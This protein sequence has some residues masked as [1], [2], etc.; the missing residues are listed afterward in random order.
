MAFH[1]TTQPRM[2]CLPLPPTWRR[3]SHLTQTLEF[4]QDRLATGSKARNLSLRQL[5]G[6]ANEMR[7][8]GLTSIAPGLIHPVAVTDQDAATILDQRPEGFL[9]TLGMNTVQGDGIRDHAP[10]PLQGMAAVPGRLVNVAHPCLAGQASNGRIVRHNSQGGTVDETPNRPQADWRTQHRATEI[11][12]AAPGDAV[13]G[14]EFANQGRQTRAMA[15]L[16]R[17]GEAG[18]E[19]PATA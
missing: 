16:L 15:G 1:Q 14:T 5:P 12:Y 8:A 3:V 2:P 17:L 4:L 13:H 10:E 18:L 7:Q 9:R 11:L 6:T 19:Q